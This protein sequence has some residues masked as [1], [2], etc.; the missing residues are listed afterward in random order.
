MRKVR[1]ELDV[2]VFILHVRETNMENT[3]HKYVAY[4]HFSVDRI[5]WSVRIIFELRDCITCIASKTNTGVIPLPCHFTSTC[6][7]YVNL[8]WVT[9]DT[10]MKFHWN[11]FS[12]STLVVHRIIPSMLHTRLSFVL[13]RHY[14]I[15]TNF[16]FSVRKP[17]FTS[18]IFT[19]YSDILA[20]HVYL[21]PGYLP[22]WGAP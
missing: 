11:S 5:F 17:E 6:V 20:C 9:W 1:S 13:H 16:F 12:P 4:I 22:G 18:M 10:W 19:N 14:E 2:S 21:R 7:R 3:G 15:L 8:L